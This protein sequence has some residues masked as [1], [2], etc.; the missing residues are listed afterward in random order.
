MSILVVGSVAYDTVQTPVGNRED[1]L[2]GSATYFSVSASKFESVSIVAVVGTD[3][4]QEHFEMLTSHGVDISGIE[5]VKGSTFRWS[6][7]YGADAN[8][9]ETLDTQLNVFAQFTP[10]LGVKHRE[11]SYLF[12]ANIEPSIQLDVLHQMR[13]R[14]KLVALDTMNFW[15][16][17]K[18]EQLGEVLK[19]VDVV[20]MDENETRSF[21]GKQNLTE[22]AGYIH[23]IGPHTVIVKRGEHG[24]LLFRQ[25]SVFTAP[26]V[27]LRSVVDPTGAGDCF[28]GGFMGYLA[29]TGDLS[30]DG[31][32]RAVVLGSV[33]GSF[34]VE[35][36][37]LDR[38]Q[39]VSGEEVEERFRL[40]TELTR[41]K[42]LLDRETLPFSDTG[43]QV[44]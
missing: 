3:F 44:H 41:F 23:E 22:A 13:R 24:V 19:E 27:P 17:G 14:P 26:A 15:I 42:P 36:F 18:R 4:L 34:A 39:S 28:A 38:V 1:A 43:H 20:L 40:I 9:R 31:F 16:E 35:S 11:H 10:E 12:L 32:R 37:S 21:A 5:S 33:M 8:T 2:G 6:G 29:S 7:V 30:D 25:G